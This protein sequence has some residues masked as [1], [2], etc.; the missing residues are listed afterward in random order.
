MTVTDKVCIDCS[1]EMLLENSDADA[2]TT[3]MESTTI[4]D[5]SEQQ[6]SVAAWGLP[7]DRCISPGE[8]VCEVLTAKI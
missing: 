1:D 7:S 8:S 6:W 4:E 2:I 3:F 5:P